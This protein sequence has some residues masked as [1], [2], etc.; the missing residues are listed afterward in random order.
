MLETSVVLILLEWLV[1]VRCPVQ[2]L[3]QM[4]ALQRTC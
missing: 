4:D 3:Q 2:F 1:K